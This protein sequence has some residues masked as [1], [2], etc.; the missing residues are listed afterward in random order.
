M[1]HAKAFLV[2]R[3]GEF[4]V[5]MMMMMDDHSKRERGTKKVYFCQHLTRNYHCAAAPRGGAARL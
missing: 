4:V 5:V 3:R 1:R 2:Q